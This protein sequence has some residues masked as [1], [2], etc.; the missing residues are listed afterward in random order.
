MAPKKPRKRRAMPHGENDV[1]ESAVLDRDTW[2]GWVEMESEPAFFNAML[3]DLGVSGARVQE[4]YSL[5]SEMLAILPQ[6]VHALIFLFKYKDFSAE[7][8]EES[9]CPDQVWFANQ[10]PDFACASIALLNIIN[11]IPDLKTGKELRDFAKFTRDMTPLDRGI[12]IDSFDFVRR[13]HNSF[14]REIDILN[15]DMHLSSRVAKARKKAAVK[16]AAESR[17]A[18]AATSK[19]SQKVNETIETTPIER[20]ARAARSTTRKSHGSND[21]SGSQALPTVISTDMHFSKQPTTN[22]N[23]YTEEFATKPVLVH[24][25]ASS[26]DTP[27]DQNGLRRSSRQPQPRKD[28]KSFVADK[29]DEANPDDEGFHFIAYMPINDHVW[30]LDGMDAWPTDLGSFAPEEGGSWLNIAQPALQARILQYTAD[31]IHFNLMAVCHDPLVDDKE[32]LAKNVKSIKAINQRLDALDTAWR[33]LEGGETPGDL[34]TGVSEEYDMSQS[35]LEQIE[36]EEDPSPED[37]LLELIKHRKSLTGQQSVLRAAVRDALKQSQQD[38][39]EARQ[40]QHNYSGFVKGWLE[41]LAENET[42]TS[43]L[44]EL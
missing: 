41:A 43:L 23:G 42:L 31:E 19:N 8:Q 3:H 17:K 18:K 10:V 7:E 9:S 28:M 35:D 5:D 21:A 12:A 27:S 20:P 24:D 29:D 15:A 1:P 13:V 30:K 37:N 6:P 25:N 33:E 14:A 2:P 38:I 44:E 11:N 34:I 16:K 36:D 26:L 22:M 32:R 39:I 40:R 4:V